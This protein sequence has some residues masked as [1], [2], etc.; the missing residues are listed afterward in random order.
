MSL[1]SLGFLFLAVQQG[2]LGLPEMHVSGNASSAY[3]LNWYQDR[4]SGQLPHAWVF[5][6]P[7][8]VYRL[9]MLAWALWLAFALLKWLR[10]GW[11][12]VNQHGLWITL[13]RKKTKALAATGE[14]TPDKD[15]E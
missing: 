6:V 8:F 10:W 5:S 13:E 12:C 15:T 14:I 3:D 9:L 2:L 1:L 7:L 4:S 11:Q